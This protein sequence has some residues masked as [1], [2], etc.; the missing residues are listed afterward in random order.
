MTGP[1]VLTLLPLLLLFGL[2][3]HPLHLPP[4]LASLPSRMTGPSI[5][6][7]LAL[8]PCS[9]LL[10]G[11]GLGVAR[12]AASFLSL[13]G[14]LWG[15]W[16][17]FRHAGV[18]LVSVAAAAVWAG[19]GGSIAFDLVAL[20]A[21][22]GGGE[23]LYRVFGQRL[24]LFLGALAAADCLI[25][26]G[27]LTGSLFAASVDQ[28]NPLA[29]RP[30]SFSGVVVDGSFLGGIDLACAV[31]IGFELQRRN[32]SRGRALAVFVAYAAAQA[33]LVSVAQLHGTALP[34]TLPP[35]V[36][37]LVLRARSRVGTS[38]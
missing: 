28:G 33:L 18:V 32:A 36:A 8:I 38:I 19:A 21:A 15:G 11:S 20:G 7:L 24:L 26:S 22:I 1:L 31:L 12:L 25:V 3:L 30:P 6:V 16:R 17:L 35:L 23:L 29:V 13:A 5:L 27:G 2:R 14:A 4:P 9:L 37:L 10:L 34:A